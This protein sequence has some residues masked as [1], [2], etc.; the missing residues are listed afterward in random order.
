[1]EPST[2]HGIADDVSSQLFDFSLWIVGHSR[3]LDSDTRFDVLILVVES[4]R[5][6]RHAGVFKRSNFCES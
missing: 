2:L 6:Q 4:V 5:I 3:P 1:V